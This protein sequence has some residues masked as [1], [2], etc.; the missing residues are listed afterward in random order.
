MD[1]ELAR[2]WRPAEAGLEATFLSKR[3]RTSEKLS[4]FKKEIISS[5]LCPNKQRLD[6]FSLIRLYLLV[7]TYGSAVGVG[8]S[9][10]VVLSL[11]AV[12][13]AATSSV[14]RVLAGEQEKQERSQT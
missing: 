5:P 8:V 4:P 10:A 7:T 12:T 1:Q 3:W 11:I 6:L 13:I 14:T 9:I 2:A